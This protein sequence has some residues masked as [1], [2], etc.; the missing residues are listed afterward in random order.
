MDTKI[1]T[2]CKKKKSIDDFYKWK[3]ECK[4]CTNK[5][6]VLYPNYKSNSIKQNNLKSERLEK[7]YKDWLHIRLKEI[8]SEDKK[9]DEIWKNIPN[10]ENIYQASNSGRIRKL[11][12]V[13]RSK[14]NVLVKIDLY[15]P[16][17]STDKDGYKRVGLTDENGKTY[18]KGVHRWIMYAFE[19]KSNLEV[20]HKNGVKSDNNY[21][22]LRYVTTRENINHKKRLNIGKYSS[23]LIGT[24]LHKG[25][26]YSYIT[27]NGKEYYLGQFDTDTEGSAAYKKALKK[28][29]ENGEYPEKPKNPRK[30]SDYIGV[31]FHKPSGKW[32]AR[33]LENKYL[34]LYGKE[35]T[36]KRV[37]DLANYMEF[38]RGI[39]VNKS[40]ISKLKNKYS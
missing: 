14:K 19:G 29:K 7:E 33:N 24:Y 3:N 40:I 6:R 37:V 34:G 18:T 38:E 27:L 36:A 4:K 25:K 10:F 13:Y 31:G 23:D 2:K 11:P 12:D 21:K 35:I 17:Y 22:N 16:K 30:T 1:C 15:Y 20:D 26:W 5:R 39:E 8:E 28:W 9:S 32:R